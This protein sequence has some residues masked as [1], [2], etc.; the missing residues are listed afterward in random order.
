MFCI[1]CV[2]Y[3]FKGLWCYIMIFFI[4]RLV[5]YRVSHEGVFMRLC[6]WSRKV[7]G[8]E[9]VPVTSLLFGRTT[10]FHYEMA[11]RHMDSKT[12][13]IWF[14]TSVATNSFKLRWLEYVAYKWYLFLPFKAIQI[15]QLPLPL[16]P[17]MDQLT[18]G[19]HKRDIFLSEKCLSIY[20]ALGRLW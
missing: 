2:I 7:V 11:T 12:N 13:P 5:I 19:P 16:S 4:L 6:G 1:I 10:G 14:I 20:Q 18:W 9:W 15:S 8:E 3:R 17:Q